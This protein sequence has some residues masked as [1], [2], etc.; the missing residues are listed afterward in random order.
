M[1]DNPQSAMWV[2]TLKVRIKNIDF[3]IAY[4]Y[5]PYEN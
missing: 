4:T 2:N 3:A 1:D 5:N